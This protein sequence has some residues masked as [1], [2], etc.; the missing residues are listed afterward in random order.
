M[1][2]MQ[3]VEVG[4]S[5]QHLAHHVAGIS[6][7]VVALVQDPIKHLP[8]CGTMGRTEHRGVESHS[9][10]ENARPLS[11]LSGISKKTTMAHPGIRRGH[12]LESGCGPFSSLYFIFPCFH[13]LCAELHIKGEIIIK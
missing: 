4:N 9:F 3:G 11:L 2:D 7:R 8:T 6:L 1:N 10:F 5:L 13:L 12:L